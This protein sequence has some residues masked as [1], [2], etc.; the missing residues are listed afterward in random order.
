M[1]TNSFTSIATLNAEVALDLASGVPGSI[2]PFGTYIVLGNATTSGT[3]NWNGVALSSTSSTTNIN[4]T[5]TVATTAHLSATYIDN[6]GTAS[7]LTAN[8]SPQSA[9]VIDSVA[10]AVGNTVVVK[11]QYNVFTNGIYS[12]TNIGSSSTN[13]VLTR[14]SSITLYHGFTIGIQSGTLNAGK[15]FTVSPSTANNV[16]L[17]GT[18]RP[19]LTTTAIGGDAIL[20]TAVDISPTVS[21]TD[22]GNVLGISSTDNSIKLIPQIYQKTRG[23]VKSFGGQSSMTEGGAT[24]K[25]FLKFRAPGHFTRV[26]IWIAGRGDTSG[27]QW[28]ARVA[29]TANPTYTNFATA[30]F[31]QTTSTGTLRAVPTNGEYFIVGNW[32]TISVV[33]TLP[34]TSW[35][36]LGWTQANNSATN[37]ATP[38]VGDQFLCN[39]GGLLSA[40]V[41]VS[42]TSWATISG[43]GIATTL[44]QNYIAGAGNGAL[45]VNNPAPYSSGNGWKLVSWD[46]GN[47]TSGNILPSSDLRIYNPKAAASSNT[48]GCAIPDSIVSD[49]VTLQSLAPD[50][51]GETKPCLIVVLEKTS[52]S[53]SSATSTRAP[54]VYT[55]DYNA[56]IAYVPST[57]GI[58]TNLSACVYDTLPGFNTATTSIPYAW[59]EYDFVQPTRAFIGIGDSITE[60]YNLWFGPIS[61]QSSIGKPFTYTNLA[62]SSNQSVEFIKAAMTYLKKGLPVTDIIYPLTSPNDPTELDTSDYWTEYQKTKLM[63]MVDFCNRY[64]IKL[65]VWFGGW[66]GWETGAG[67]NNSTGATY[68]LFGFYYNGLANWVK[69]QYVN[70][71]FYKLIDV[72][73]HWWSY[74]VSANQLITLPGPSLN[75]AWAS[76]AALLAAYPI[77]GTYSGATTNYCI[78]NV[79]STGVT[80]DMSTW[81][82]YFNNGT[83]WV[84]TTAA[85]VYLGNFASLS[86]PN[87]PS[88]LGQGGGII[89]TGS[90]DI[91]A[92]QY[93]RSEDTLGWVLQNAYI[94]Q[95]LVHPSP[96]AQSFCNNL[97]ANILAGE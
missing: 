38:A 46:N 31:P 83:A 2:L 77:G 94:G 27:G 72:R 36:A 95:S 87:L 71:K 41:N 10:L 34:T 64:N 61:K 45:S 30:F 21:L 97:F 7:T 9:L 16:L 1:K 29:S 42:P 48:G 81:V 52:T 37:I 92:W 57:T 70:G 49:W 35:A 67:V 68:N 4:A 24:G 54:S 3:Y 47:T 65:W 43:G 74:S 28:Q 6:G 19:L 80:A 85:N 22:G 82:T 84:V 33:G 14:V 11:N 25:A 5:A 66:D 56:V 69:Q 79:S 20:F 44:Y 8:I 40:G 91:T 32:Y 15:T 23:T 13:W 62:M 75:N 17:D 58:A 89:S 59:I 51:A 53:Q 86:D 55:P 73:T 26:R 90:T 39:P 60:G 18:A 88:A 76:T 93:Y 63:D 96:V 12:V 78:A 50:G